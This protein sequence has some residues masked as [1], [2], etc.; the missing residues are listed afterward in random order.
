MNDA[1]D[2]APRAGWIAR[3]IAVSATNPG[4]TVLF[5]AALALWGWYALVRS[6]LDAIPD[7]SDVQVIVF[8]EWQG[9]SPDIV[10]DQVTFPLATAL[11]AAPRVAFVRGQSMF[12]MSFL[13]VIFEDG[14]DLYWARSRVLEYLDEARARLPEGVTPTLGPDATGVGWVYQYALVDRTG[15]LDLQELR[16]LQDWNVRFALE[17]VPG[18]AEVASVGGFVKEYQIVVDPLKLEAF[19]ISIQEVVRAVRESNQEVGGQ[20]FEMAE[21]EVMVRGRGWVKSRRDLELVPLRANERGVPVRIADVAEV[22]LGPA[23]RR[24]FGELDGQGEAVGGIVVMRHGENA[25]A[26]ID[27]V[28]ERL[29]EVR[30]SLPEGVELVVTY[31]RS[32]LIRESIDTLTHTLVE[33]MLVVS[34]VIFFFLLHA[35]S[36]LVAIVTLPVAVLLSFIPM[37]AQ[38]LTANIMSL[39]GIAVAIGELVDASIIVIENIHKR[40]ERWEAT[41]RAEP[42]HQVVVAAMQEVGP[43]LFFSLLVMTVSFLPVFT[44]EGVEGRL[45]K[46]LAFTKTYSMGFGA[47]LAVTLTPA[48]AALF[49][50]GRIRREDASPV[51]RWLIRL[52]TPV[53]R[54]VVRWRWAVVAVAA[55]ATIATVPAFLAL[56]GEFMPPLQEGAILY[57]PT[58]P[59]GMGASEAVRVLQDMDRKLRA[60]PEVVSVFGK[61]GRAE[62]A[63]DPAPIGMVETVVV[64]KPRKEWRPGLTWDGLIAEMDAK[65]SYPGMP[66]IWWMPIQTRTEMLSTGIRAPLGVKVF[67]D[68]LATVERTAVE[69]EQAVSGIPGT[70]SAFADRATGG[71]YLDLEVDREAAAR[72][73]VRVADVQDVVATAIGGMAVAETVEGRQRYPIAVRYARGFREDPRWLERV[74]VA[75]PSGAQVALRQVARITFA[76]GPPMIRSEDGRLV[77]YVFVDP[78]ERPLAAYVEEARQAVAERVT[79]PAGV[80]I[81]WAGQFRNYERARERLKLVVPVT[82][83]VI[84]LLLYLSTRSAVEVGIVLLAVP[85]SL[86]GAVWLL[87]LLD[88]NLS[89]AVWVGLIA[90][91]GLDAETGVVMLLYLKLAWQRRREEGRLASFDDLREAIV[92]GAAQRIRPKLMTVLTTV[93]GLLPVMWST[94]TGAD[95]MKRIAAPLFGGIVTSF[96]LELTVYPAIFALWKRRDF[97]ETPAALPAAE[98]PAA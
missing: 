60:F 18:V 29:E 57:M 30:A 95:V 83:L 62:S 53:V 69:I 97:L 72:Y 6:P 76:T 16:S 20:V 2:T 93:I 85:F 52:Y 84:V 80:R 15:R 70:R 17:S 96:L 3:T 5:V 9:Q 35:R 32:G 37:S 73:G 19:G 39:G 88:Y 1:P 47:L 58:A 28:K 90:L 45:F 98:E 50:R 21:H 67:G 65:L 44:L 82:L 89:V 91:A 13:Y 26:V 8:T 42:R 11:L 66:N 92:E 33:Q 68:D 12:G 7:L 56:E 31:D 74:L 27:A 79:L 75:A 40:L 94:G 63:T 22:R 64:L 38:G 78:G 25:L 51:N 14:T 34:L 4:L 86:I 48:L 49:I 81:E 55:L 61:M 87:W 36:S 46:P 59:P 23:P 24:G 10:E 41:G 43:S 71:F 77:G 54:F